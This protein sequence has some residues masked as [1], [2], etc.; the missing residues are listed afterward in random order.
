MV[1]WPGILL[2]QFKVRAKKSENPPAQDTKALD[3]VTSAPVWMTNSEFFGNLFSSVVI[4]Y[5]VYAVYNNVVL[6]YFLHTLYN[7]VVLQ[8]LFFFFLFFSLLKSKIKL[9]FSI[10]L[11]LVAH[12]LINTWILLLFSSIN[13]RKCF[14]MFAHYLTFSDINWCSGLVSRFTFVNIYVSIS[15]KTLKPPLALITR[16]VKLPCTTFCI[17]SLQCFFFSLS[18]ISRFFCGNV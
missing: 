7:N 2:F 17:L 15:D 4:N 6:N 18:F 5:L 10:I 1:S 12:L 9:F 16:G 11:Q 14:T 8:C 13:T 3:L